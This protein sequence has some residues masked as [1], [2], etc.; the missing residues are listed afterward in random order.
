[1]LVNKLGGDII[2]N[3]F[4]IELSALE[5]REYLESRGVKVFSLEKFTDG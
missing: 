5:G 1:V 3:A 4:L 2:E